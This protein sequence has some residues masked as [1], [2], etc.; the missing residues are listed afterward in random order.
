MDGVW[1]DTNG[2]PLLFLKS[3][4]YTFM[5]IALVLLGA[6]MIRTGGLGFGRFLNQTPNSSFG[7]A[8]SPPSLILAHTSVFYIFI[9]WLMAV[10]VELK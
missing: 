10:M 4:S 1:F 8:T 9:A 7:R 6:L 3:L 2:L 5:R